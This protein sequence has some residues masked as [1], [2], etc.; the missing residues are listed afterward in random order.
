MAEAK[1]V[2]IR[3]K[4]NGVTYIYLDEPY[5]DSDKKVGRHKR[6]GIGKIDE[7]GNEVYNEYYRSLMSS[8]AE[9]PISI[10]KSV[11]LGEKL[12]CRK[13]AKETGLSSTLRKA[14]G[15]DQAEMIEA[16]AG[17]LM[18]ESRPLAYA[19]PW[20]DERDWKSGMTSQAISELLGSVGEDRMNGFFSL[21]LKRCMGRKSILFD[22]T[23]I[24]SYGRDNGYVE[25][26]YNRDRENLEQINLALLSTYDTRTPLMMKHLSGSL[27]DV[28]VMRQM[29]ETLA[30]MGVD[31]FSIMADRGF[32]SDENLDFMHSRKIGFT[33]PVPSSV[34]WQKQ[35]IRENIGKLYRPDALISAPDGSEGIIYA[36]TVYDASSPY[37][38]VWKHLYYDPMRKERETAALMARLSRCMDDLRRGE[39]RE[40][41]SY[42]YE[43]YFHV[44]ETPKRG[45]QVRLD[46]EAVQAFIDGESCYWVILSSVEKD[47][48]A[49]LRQY[50]ERNNI[51]LH[52]DDL[53]N[54]TD[55]RRLRTHNERTMVGRL[56]V[57]FISL[58]LISRLRSAV[59]EI[60]AKERRH[61]NWKEILSHSAS[62]GKC[63]FSGRYK[64]VYT[65]PNKG[66][67]MIFNALGISYYWKGKLID[68][69]EG[70]DI[71]D[72]DET[73]EVC[74]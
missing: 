47:A 74:S 5:W 10:S 8:A 11:K 16:L 38:R 4:G 63:I 2:Y 20:L 6:K 54:A 25:R 29:I 64:D 33:I 51:E 61:W 57:S 1:K 41:D 52:F 22:I 34:G 17:Y 7:N 28:A 13:I 55:C 42:L 56:F 60:P 43:A 27:S 14:F 24:S 48:S 73:E 49:C 59:S 18:C 19:E 67:R 9:E 3:N 37:G 46:D 70:K 36:K 45:R 50:R 58:I 21:W 15:N 68:K 62:Y 12:I 39:T 44:K 31:S 69:A 71:C 72:D 35:L 65:A 30:K 53:K 26:G 23:S 32:C 40:A 66:Q